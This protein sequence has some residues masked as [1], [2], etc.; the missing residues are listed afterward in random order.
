MLDF[1][2]EYLVR[3]V[4]K[5]EI[6]FDIES[7]PT[8]RIG[9]INVCEKRPSDE[10]QDY[11]LFLMNR[12]VGEKLGIGGNGSSA[13]NELYKHQLLATRYLFH[14]DSLLLL[15]EAGTGKTETSQVSMML[16][17]A[18]GLIDKIMIINASPTL[19]IKARNTFKNIFD[20]KR[21]NSRFS[22]L[23]VES[24]VQT[25]VIF[26]TYH[27]LSQR[28]EEEYPFNHIGVIFDEAHILVSETKSLKRET[29]NKLVTVLSQAKGCK[30]RS[31]TATPIINKGESFSI[32][33]QLLLRSPD[34][35]IELPGELVS[36][37]Q[38]VYDH[39]KIV[40]MYNL[41]DPLLGVVSPKKADDADA[42]TSVAPFPIKVY[43]V[44]PQRC[45]M[46]N[47]IEDL[48]ITDKSDFMVHFDTF[49]IGSK[50]KEVDTR[51]HRLRSELSLLGQASDTEADDDVPTEAGTP[52]VAPDSVDPSTD[53]SYTGDKKVIDSC[54]MEE[55]VKHIR[56]SKDGV[57]I[58]YMSLREKGS[59]VIA[60]L[61][62][63]Y[64]FEQYTGVKSGSGKPT[65][66][67]YE[68]NQ[69]E[70]KIKLFEHA[71]RPEN[72]NGSVVKVIVGSR[73]M[74]DSVDI[75]HVT[76]VH[77]AQSEW[78][79][80]GLIQAWHR[81]IR[82]NGHNYLIYQRALQLMTENPSLSLEEARKRVVIDYQIFNYVIDI[83]N[84]TDVEIN[85]A[86]K[87]FDGPSNAS[88]S[89]AEIKKRVD[90]RNPSLRKI[91]IALQKYQEVG[92]IMRSL[93]ENSQDYRLNSNAITVPANNNHDY[94][95]SD[96]FFLSDIYS[97]IVKFIEEM[98]TSRFH[99]KVS[100]LIRVVKCK[101][102]YFTENRIVSSLVQM[103]RNNYILF[104]PK[105]G[106][107][108]KLV[109]NGEYIYLI[110]VA[111]NNSTTYSDTNNICIYNKGMY[112][113]EVSPI[114]PT[115]LEINRS[116]NTINKLKQ[117][118][119]T[120]MSNNNGTTISESDGLIYAFLS[121]MTNFWGFTVD[122]S[123]RP[124]V[125]IFSRH[126]SRCSIHVKQKI[127]GILTLAEGN[128]WIL[129]RAQGIQITRPIELVEKYEEFDFEEI[130]EITC[131]MR[132]YALRTNGLVMLKTKRTSNEDAPAIG[133]YGNTFVG[134]IEKYLESLGVNFERLTHD[135]VSVKKFANIRSKGRQLEIKT[136]GDN[137][138]V[139]VKQVLIDELSKGIYFI[140]FPYEEAK[141]I[142]TPDTI[143]TG[144]S[145]LD[146]LIRLKREEHEEKLR[147]QEGKPSWRHRILLIEYL[148]ALGKITTERKE[149]IYRA[150]FAV[151]IRNDIVAT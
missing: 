12:Q 74:R 2:W 54:I 41:N 18:A 138:V 43:R 122:N 69:G 56:L 121:H 21:F 14:Q 130:P 119:I 52:L 66:L 32:I 57:V 142:N 132:N 129:S 8:I 68:S 36:Y 131:D 147:A 143:E 117:S 78:H 100:E 4:I 89:N 45:Q 70:R 11:N 115:N 123:E 47:I 146:R 107:H 80:P 16:L 26:V 98:I 50:P 103:S 86:K 127:K 140:F 1:A 133:D 13:R 34:I 61:L 42:T 94:S 85:N 19:N 38:A 30:V 73:V 51:I 93:R 128:E 79:I 88:L 63:F 44:R 106:I 124:N 114:E 23:T 25:Y 64:G 136:T 28:L 49:S 90:E 35:S 40:P 37:K 39:L 76:Q 7:R 71:K 134:F 110:S 151:P 120:A 81:G 105:F 65:F 9:N 59:K 95:G 15:H 72:W 109:I 144:V 75:H 29:S 62:E 55:I 113:I 60:Q 99:L 108:M 53:T 118:L 58:I 145:L 102:S 126:V 46:A 10:L 148:H 101:Y 150:V 3:C 83:A 111:S 5:M 31:C 67:L 97:L 141:V 82:S 149:E 84:L 22:H 112:A 27:G 137:Q 91:E 135:M 139:T 17:L 48:V 6:P 96:C 24:F 125:Y 33:K 87:L 92:E 77:I 20:L 104:I 116:V